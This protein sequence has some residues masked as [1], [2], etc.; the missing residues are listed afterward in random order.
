MNFTNIFLIVILKREECII[1][2]GDSLEL[3]FRIFNVKY[4]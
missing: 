2:P 4:F 3:I 1:K